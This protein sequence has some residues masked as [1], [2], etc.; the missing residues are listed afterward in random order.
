MSPVGVKHQPKLAAEPATSALGRWLLTA[1]CRLLPCRPTGYGL[2]TAASSAGWAGAGVIDRRG[3]GCDAPGDSCFGKSRTGYTRVGGRSLPIAIVRDPGPGRAVCRSRRSWT[4]RRRSRGG[5][6]AADERTWA[7]RGL[8]WAENARR[9][10]EDRRSGERFLVAR[11]RAGRRSRSLPGGR[12]LVA[13]SR[14]ETAFACGPD[15][16]VLGVRGSPARS[17]A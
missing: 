2:A 11:S 17:P 15:S 9:S 13:T 8:A 4:R 14:A 12:L 5:A 3:S 6:I 16:V 1:R 7:D 10:G